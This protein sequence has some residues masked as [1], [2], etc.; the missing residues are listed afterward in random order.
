M[1][2]VL[3]AAPAQTR[4]A[5][6]AL[7]AKDGIAAEG[8]LAIE[9]AIWGLRRKAFAAFVGRWRSLRVALIHFK[10]WSI[11]TRGIFAIRQI[12]FRAAAERGS[13]PDILRVCRSLP[14]T[15]FGGE[16]TFV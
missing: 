14:M 6:A 4:N 8:D 15:G 1:N 13:S 9:S 11:G 7:E 12:L 5:K 2:L 10:R 16:A 3:C